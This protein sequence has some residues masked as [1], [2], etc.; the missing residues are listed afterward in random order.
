M[1]LQPGVKLNGPS[2]TISAERVT[3]PNK[4]SISEYRKLGEPK[5]QQL[6]STLNVMQKQKGVSISKLALNELTS[7]YQSFEPNQYR[8]YIL[9]G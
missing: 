1:N 3:V 5:Q 9:E 7:P 6:R 4:I 2:Q 8:E